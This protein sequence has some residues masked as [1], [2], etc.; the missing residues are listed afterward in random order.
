MVPLLKS[1]IFPVF[2]D[3]FFKE[4]GADDHHV[5]S[6]R[7]ATPATNIK[8]SNTGFELE[9]A[10]PG[11]E[12]E[13]FKIDLNK[14]TLTISSKKEESKEEDQEQDNGK[15]TRREFSYHSFEKAFTLPNTINKDAI[16]ASYKNGVLYVSLPKVET[17][18]EKAPREIEIA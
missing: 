14:N 11:L 4:F 5:K 18:V 1:R 2:T 3:E 8:E 13:D 9:L 7:C 15:Y 12:K 16:G 6:N 17:A 10:V